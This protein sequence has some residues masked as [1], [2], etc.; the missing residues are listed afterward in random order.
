M[1]II[2]LNGRFVNESPVFLPSDR[3]RIGD[4]VFDTMLAVDGV[5]VHANEHFKRLLGHADVLRHPAPPQ[6]STTSPVAS[7]TT[8]SS[9]SPAPPNLAGR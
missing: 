1:N 3:I 2:W 8:R 9:P 7:T 5:P 6:P 4:G